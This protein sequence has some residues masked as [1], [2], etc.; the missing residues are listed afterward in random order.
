[1]ANIS[2][3]V[4]A[5]LSVTTVAAAS[6]AVVLAVNNGNKDENTNIPEQSVVEQVNEEVTGVKKRDVIVNEENVEKIA[7]EIIAETHVPPGNYN[8]TMSTT[9]HFTD[10][11]SGSYDSY[12]ENS[13]RNTNDVYF[14]IVRSDTKEMIYSSPVISLGAKIEDI[15]LDTPLEAGTYD[16][17]LTYHL[18][19]KEQN[20]ISKLN[21]S[22]EIIVEN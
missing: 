12:V 3:K 6:T 16:C 20:P 18:V 10:G 8:V 7:E 2:G 11:S 5:A 4:I 15:T 14:D 22:L 21:V 13:E 9:W 1:M 19:D 17:V